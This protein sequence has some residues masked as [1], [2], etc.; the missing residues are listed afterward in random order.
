MIASQAQYL[1]RFD[2][3]CATMKWSNWDL[4]EEILVGHGIKPIMAIVPDNRDS[5]LKVQPP[6][7]D[8]WSRVRR[9]QSDGWALGMHGFQHTYVTRDPGLYS[10][11]KASEF[12][13]LPF[14]VQ[15]DKLR[16]AAAILKEEGVDSNLWIAP[17]HSFDRT[18][19]AALK[20]VGLTS[21]SDGFSRYPYTDGGGMFWIPQ[22]QLSENEMLG[23][24]HGQPA[25][26]KSNGVWTICLHPNAWSIGDIVRFKSRVEK[27]RPLIGTV[28]EVYQSFRGRRLTWMDRIHIT[29]CEARRRARLFIEKPM[30]L[31]QAGSANEVCTPV[32]G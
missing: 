1:L 30:L 23:P 25:K 13:G 20:A 32:K 6:N 2:D 14:E 16:R 9:W 24:P 28:D 10:Y 3:I 27:L 29:K 12:A 26:P 22:Q 18:T 5:Y 15:C 17:G 11:Q 7:P 31:E 21:I 4:I 19:V 8:F